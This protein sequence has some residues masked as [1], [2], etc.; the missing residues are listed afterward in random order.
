[1][2]T[3]NTND[4]GTNDRG[5]TAIDLMTEGD[6]IIWFYVDRDGGEY[7]SDET[8]TSGYEIHKLILG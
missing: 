1:M 6:T 2:S 3:Y 4:F 8:P 7:Q 5:D